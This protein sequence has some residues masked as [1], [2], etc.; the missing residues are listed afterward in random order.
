MIV[1]P[2]NPMAIR[3]TVQEVVPDKGYWV[4]EPVGIVNNPNCIYD[5]PEAAVETLRRIHQNLGDK[6]IITV[7]TW[8]LEG[9]RSF[10]LSTA[11]KTNYPH[12]DKV[13]SSVCPPKLEGEG[14]FKLKEFANGSAV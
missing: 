14:W 2:Y 1:S 8:D 5:T 4:D 7:H 3:V 12:A 11:K 10:L 9:L 6:A 13:I